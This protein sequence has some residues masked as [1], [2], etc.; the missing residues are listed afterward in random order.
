MSFLPRCSSSIGE[1]AFVISHHRRDGVVREFRR[2]RLHTASSSF[3][4]HQLLH[5]SIP[6]PLHLWVVLSAF[7]VVSFKP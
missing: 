5:V 6:Q 1:H 2:R 7:A 4:Q 3:C